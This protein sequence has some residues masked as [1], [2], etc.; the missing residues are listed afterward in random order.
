M[1]KFNF[2]GGLR[3]LAITL[4]IAMLASPM[5]SQELRDPTRPGWSPPSKS[6]SADKPAPAQL[7]AILIGE[8]KRLALFG[9]RYLGIGDSVAGAKLIRID[10]DYIVLRDNSGERVLRLTPKLDSRSA[11]KVTGP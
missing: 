5:Y 10:F 8:H 6:D 1:A 3:A 4:L 7:T 11:A 9:N 2:V